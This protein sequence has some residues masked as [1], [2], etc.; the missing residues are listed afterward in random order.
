MREAYRLISSQYASCEMM[1]VNA[2]RTELSLESCRD[3]AIIGRKMMLI[4]A[5]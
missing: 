3:L 2:E 1:S 4:Y 5:M